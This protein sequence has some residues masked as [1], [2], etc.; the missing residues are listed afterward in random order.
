MIPQASI[1]DWIFLIFSA[2]TEST[3][4]ISAPYITAVLIDLIVVGSPYISPIATVIT[5]SDSDD[6]GSSCLAVKLQS[7]QLNV[8]Y[9][10]GAFI[11]ALLHQSVVQSKEGTK[12]P[13]LF[14]LSSTNLVPELL[15]ELEQL[16]GAVLTFS[17]LLG[18]DVPIVHVPRQHTI[19]ILTVMEYHTII[20]CSLTF[21]C[22]IQWLNFILM[23]M[24]D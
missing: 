21:C 17:L 5:T 22:I 19:A 18:D 10:K 13:A 9:L 20:P 16:N 12:P 24:C 2:A 23:V 4:T 14:A 11:A 15:T 3:R 1:I 6:E 7:G 8:E